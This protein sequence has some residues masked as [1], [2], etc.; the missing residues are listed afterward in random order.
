MLFESIIVRTKSVFA[1]K[2][3]KLGTVLKSVFSS[4]SNSLILRA[5]NLSALKGY[6]TMSYWNL[7]SFLCEN[8]GF[9]F[10]I[11]NVL[12][13]YKPQRAYKNRWDFPKLS[14]SNLSLAFS[15]TFIKKTELFSEKYEGRTYTLQKYTRVYR[16]GISPKVSL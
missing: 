11:R 16:C 1:L 5:N 12:Y 3:D 15:L 13:S 10:W 9:S 2:F 14:W 6:A 7:S 4:F 8:G